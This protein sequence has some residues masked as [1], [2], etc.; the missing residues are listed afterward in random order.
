[1][2]GIQTTLQFRGNLE[3][4]QQI[5]LESGRLI[6]QAID[7]EV[8]R[9]QVPINGASQQP[10]TTKLANHEMSVELLVTVQKA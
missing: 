10:Y 6:I 8:V 1:M 2:K 7:S 5:R 4:P 9:N 3:I